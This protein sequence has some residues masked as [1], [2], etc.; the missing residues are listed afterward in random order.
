M[1]NMVCISAL[2]SLW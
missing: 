1:L 2:S